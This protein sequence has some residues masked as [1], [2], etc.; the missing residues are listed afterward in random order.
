MTSTKKQLKIEY[1]TELT[2]LKVQRSL[3]KSYPDR[4]SAATKAN[5]ARRIAHF[6]K[7]L[8]GF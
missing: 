4:A 7:M 1:T 2:L 8:A 3:N 6:E 5:V